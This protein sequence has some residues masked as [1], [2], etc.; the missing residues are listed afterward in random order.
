MDEAHAP[1]DGE[2]SHADL[3]RHLR[4]AYVVFGA[5]LVLTGVTVAVSYLHLPT[6]QAIALALVIALIISG[7]GARKGGTTSKWVTGLISLTILL[8][9]VGPLAAGIVQMAGAVAMAAQ[10][11]SVLIENGVSITAFSGKAP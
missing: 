3:D 1:H 9:L 8:A 2:H 5:L 6:H 4:A 10:I 11:R 7:L